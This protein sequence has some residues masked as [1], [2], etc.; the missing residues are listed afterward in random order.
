MSLVVSLSL[1]G[2][3][4]SF[5]ACITACRRSDSAGLPG[6]TAGPASPPLMAASRE[7]RR[8]PPLTLSGPWQLTQR[9]SSRGLTLS[10]KCRSP[11]VPAPRASK[12]ATRQSTMAIP[13][14]FTHS[15]MQQSQT[16]QQR[17]LLRQSDPPPSNS[18]VSAEV[19]STFRAMTMVRV[20]I[21][22]I[23]STEDAL[24]AVDAGAD[25][26]GFMFYEQSP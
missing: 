12:E 20:K 24:E 25:A 23:T 26:L 4:R 13:Q 3:S 5:F 6:T 19:S 17:G 22:G 16:R 1:G 14:A 2:I 15:S 8:R 11:S 18:F 7:S 9:E 21:C 10:A